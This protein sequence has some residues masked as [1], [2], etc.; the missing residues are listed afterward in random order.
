MRHVGRTKRANWRDNAKRTERI[1]ICLITV[2]VSKRIT[3]HCLRL[4]SLASLSSD[5][6]LTLASQ[7]FSFILRHLSP[8]PR[9][10]APFILPMAKVQ[11]A[12]RNIIMLQ[13]FRLE[14]IERFVPS[15]ENRM[16]YPFTKRSDGSSIH[17][18]NG[19]N[20]V[21]S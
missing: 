5:V 7:S 6:S 21:S 9:L 18:K 15:L 16:V 14:E 3:G 17:R 2:Y 13:P 4:V 20:Q 12:Q 19:L 11:Q 8:L 10:S 1:C